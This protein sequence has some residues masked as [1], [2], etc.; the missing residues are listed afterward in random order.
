MIKTETVY[1]ITM[2]RRSLEKGENIYMK[3]RF[4]VT[5][6][7]C[8]A[9][10]AH[11][12]KAVA[13]LEGV[14]KVEVNLLS[15]NMTVD[16]N[17]NSQSIDSIIHAVEKAGYGASLPGDVKKANPTATDEAQKE[18]KHRLTWSICLLIPLM[19]LSMQHMFGYPMPFGLAETENALYLSLLQL[20][21]TIP[22]MVINRKYYTVGFKTL[23]SGSPNMDSL[24]A[25]GSSASVVY[26][27]INIFFI[28]KATMAGDLEAIHHYASNLYFES[29]SMILTLITVG[30][31]L[32]ARSKG[33][34]GE[35]ISRL[36]GLAPNTVRVFRD[37]KEVEIPL[38]EV[39]VGDLVIVK[40]GERIGVDGIITEG[41]TFIDQSALTGESIPAEK[42]VG[43]RVMAATVNK[44]GAITFRAERV[45][46]DTTLSQIIRLV[47]EAGSSKAPIARLADKIS[48]VFV[49]VVI[50]IA[51]LTAIV[52]ALLGAGAEIAV[53]RAVS[54]LVIS[55]PCALGLATPVAIMVGTG[56]GAE[57]GILIKSAEAL[58][59][60]STVTAVVFDKTG[61]ITQGEPQVTDVLPVIDKKRFLDLAAAIEKKSEHPIAEAIVQYGRSLE[62][63]RMLT[64][65]FKA[66]SGLGL[67]AVVDERTYYAGNSRL[68]EDK[69][70]NL[71]QWL[72]KGRELEAQGKTVTYFAAPD[73]G[74][75]LGLIAVADTLKPTAKSAVAALKSEG[76]QVCLLTGD[77][78]AAAEAVGAAVGADQTIAEVM[79][80][81]KEAMVRSLQAAGHKV[82]MVGDGINDSPALM[83]ADVGV[84]VGAGSDIAIESADVVIIRND[85]VDAITLI[86]LS[87]AVIRNIKMNLFWAF[88]YNCLGIPLAAGVFIRLLGWSLN[89][90]IA[91]AAM[92]LS[93]VCVV[94]NALRL[95]N[96]N[97]PVY[98]NIAI[99]T[100]K[101]DHVKEEKTMKYTMKI[102]GMMC[103]HCTGRVQKALEALEGVSSVTVDLESGTATVEGGSP[104]ALRKAVVDAGYE[105]I[106]VE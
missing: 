79:P 82:M 1:D 96:F 56:K 44:N 63:E 21:L 20:V 104:E 61:T 76:I 32:E 81:D 51:L 59:T 71:G 90:M 64:S 66:L 29:A 46:E 94:T 58:E 78:K 98:S 36:V 86:K 85:P 80:Q 38:S 22:V 88:F 92:S 89:P 37:T 52:W 2:E 23:F 19:Y 53:T 10:S 16:Y 99:E 106:S 77:N 13:A 28:A 8:S 35:A 97:A 6:M 4:N 14:S 100:K 87:K 84:A 15:G 24:I 42:T 83:R 67:R 69:Q 47:E 39:K 72:Q 34:T 18:M 105:V 75:L 55:C 73:E 93:S 27:L 91:A 74:K 30:K 12:E 68:M 102:E 17:E 65:D 7:T 60:A 5:G 26:G 31:Y 41:S 25:I 57:Y 33:R 101:T 54:V 95:R 103:S 3:Q 45:G 48:G 49:P 43:D 40:P 11:V 70:I 50:S 9:C 62:S